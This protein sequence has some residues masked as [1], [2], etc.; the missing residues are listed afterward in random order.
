MKGGTSTGRPSVLGKQKKQR[1]REKKT[2]KQ[3]TREKERKRS[4]HAKKTKEA[5][6]LKLQEPTR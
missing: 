1:T 3:R 2:K 4:A 6:L 5:I